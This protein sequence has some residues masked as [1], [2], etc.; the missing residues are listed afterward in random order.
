MG[1][2]IHILLAMG[3]W[4]KTAL[5]VLLFTIVAVQLLRLTPPFR[6]QGDALADISERD[7]LLGQIGRA[8][9]PLRPIGICEFDG[10]RVECLA[11]SGYVEEGRRIEVVRVKGTQPTVRTTD[12]A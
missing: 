7:G 5:V 8:V 4:A 3:A 6:R 9:T 2:T 11:E 1:E 12:K 10:R